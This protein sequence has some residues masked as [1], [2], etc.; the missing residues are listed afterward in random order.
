MVFGI[1]TFSCDN[2]TTSSITTDTALNGTWRMSGGLIFHEEI[3]FLN[4]DY[5]RSDFYNDPPRVEHILRGTYTTNN[6]IINFNITHYHGLYLQHSIS[7]IDI[8]KW[9]TE[10]ELTQFK[11]TTTG[12]FNFDIEINY[13]PQ[14]NPYSIIGNVLTF[15][16]GFDPTYYTKVN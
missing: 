16:R 14:Y 11:N 12:N 4:G 3:T 9:Y 15:F 7:E 2:G 1:L 6:G 10:D 5:V 8:E 13:R